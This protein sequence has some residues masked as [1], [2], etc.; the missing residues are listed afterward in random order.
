MTFYETIQAENKI[1]FNE[2]KKIKKIPK[3]SF[4]TPD[5]IDVRRNLDG[6]GGE[7]EVECSA[8]NFEV[9]KY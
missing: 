2:Q 9:T 5:S 4:Q 1:I 8:T 7:T 6:K 3:V